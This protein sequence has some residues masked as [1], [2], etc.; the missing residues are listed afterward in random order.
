M[1]PGFGKFNLAVDKYLD[2]T[3]V[4]QPAVDDA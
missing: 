3:Q 2:T 1:R 4:G